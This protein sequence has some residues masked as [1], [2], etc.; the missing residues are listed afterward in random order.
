VTVGEAPGIEQAAGSGMQPEM[1]RRIPKSGRRVERATRCGGGFGDGAAFFA[2]GHV[3][4]L[5]SM[6]NK[7]ARA[8]VERLWASSRENN[9]TFVDGG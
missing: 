9:R 2:Y 4:V 1:M 5:Q 8:P 3:T 6:Q 7:N